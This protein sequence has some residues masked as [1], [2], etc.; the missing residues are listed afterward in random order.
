MKNF[1]LLVTVLLFFLLRSSATAQLQKTSVVDSTQ[2]RD[3]I[4]MM[5]DPNV[6]FHDVQNVFYKYWK[7]RTDHKGNGWKVFKRWEYINEPRVL[8]DGKLQPPDYVRNEY[9]RY[10]NNSDA[11]LSPSGSWTLVGP[12]S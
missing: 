7:N 2:N 6:R 9:I 3:W 12:T 4:E 10:M 8:P 1:K 5:Q 11:P